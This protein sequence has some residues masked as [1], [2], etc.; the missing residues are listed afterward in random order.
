[1]DVESTGATVL[2]ENRGLPTYNCTDET[3]ASKVLEMLLLVATQEDKQ[4]QTCYVACNT[5]HLSQH[6]TTL[7]S[8]PLASRT[9]TRARAADHTLL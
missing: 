7:L 6:S 5:Q 9:G 2:R 1:M 4:P 3:R 8:N